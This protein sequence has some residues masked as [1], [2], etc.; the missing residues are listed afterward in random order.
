MATRKALGRG[1]S[2]LLGGDE[3]TTA[4]SVKGHIIQIPLDRIR[5]SVNQTRVTFDKDALDEMAESIK[6]LGLINPVVV[7]ESSGFYELIAGERRWRACQKLGLKTMPA[8]VENR[9]DEDRLLMTLAENLQ[10]EDLTPVEEAQSYELMARRLNLTHEEVGQKIGKS[11]SHITNL[12]RILKLPEGVRRHIN[13]GRIGLGQAKVL[14]G[15]DEREQEKLVKRLLEG[16]V[17]VREVE[18]AAPKKKNVPR[19][20][21]GGKGLEIAHLEKKLRDHLQTKVNLEGVKG[22]KGRMVI[23]FY[24]DDNLDRL[25]KKMGVH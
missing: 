20:T 5:P 25:L 22:G 11:R 6:R 3:T 13:E 24:S 2:A 9:S 17:T 14:A 16:P 10:R 21:S 19:G 8:I 23:E 12:L 15:L 4:A 18:K 7:H 1:L